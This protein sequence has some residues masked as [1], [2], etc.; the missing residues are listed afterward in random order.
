MNMNKYM[1]LGRLFLLVPFLTVSCSEA[2]ES[3]EDY[4]SKYDAAMSAYGYIENAAAP[5]DRIVDLYTGGAE[6][7]VSVGITKRLDR[8]V[9]FQVVFDESLLPGY[10][11][12]TGNQFELFP[13]S[14]V[15][16]AG[17]GAVTVPAG[18][19]RSADLNVTIAASDELELGKTYAI[20]LRVETSDPE[21]RLSDDQRKYLFFVKYHADRI[22]PDKKA[23]FKVVSCMGPQ[24]VDP[25]LHCE[26][27]LK[28]EKKPLFDIV[29]LFS[30]NMNYDV[31]TGRVYLQTDP[32]MTTVLH[33]RERY[34][35]PLQDMGIKVVLSVMGNWDPAGVSHLERPV[36]EQFARELQA[37]A[38]AFDLDGFFWD[39]EYTEANPSIPGF[40][41]GSRENASRLIYE[42]KRLMPDKL[43]IVY[44]WSTISTL[45]TVDGVLP[46]DYVDY[47]IANYHTGI[48]IESWPG[49][50]KKQGMP[51]PYELALGYQ[52]EPSVVKNEDWGG[53]M[54]FSLSERRSNWESVQLPALEDIAETM[55][56]DELDY[57]GKK[58]P[59]EY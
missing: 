54:L 20:P 29:I 8:D 48:S 9:R 42:V 35:K 10:N 12:S 14:L 19:N 40:T 56:E 17:E 30:G 43:N 50:D 26:F 52:G 15:T 37:A 13:A 3:T 41:T 58:Y 51:Y 57:T 18:A 59:L 6:R 45:D 25:R 5:V 27:F 38:E 22:S 7:Q 55:F 53:I 32:Q 49:A 23:G 28:N 2:I 4:R 16:I 11:E 44:L 47:V 24:D 39:D 36:A 1:K 34:L 33:N 21:V 46:G 31:N